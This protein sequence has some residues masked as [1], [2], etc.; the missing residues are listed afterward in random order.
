M[1][2]T[3]T[4]VE[5]AEKLI[6]RELVKCAFCGFCEYACPTLKYGDFRRQYGPR[7]RVNAI[8]L[9]LREKIVTPESVRGIFTCLECGACTLHCPAKIDVA[10]AVRL[11]RALLI[12]GKIKVSEEV[13]K[14]V[15]MV[16]RK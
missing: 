2:L 5:N 1:I 4:K 7:G 16:S 6:Y 9:A 11:F 14:Y 10:M 3:V 13:A 8:L 15:P 12:H